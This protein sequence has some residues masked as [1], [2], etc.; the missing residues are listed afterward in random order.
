MIVLFFTYLTYLIIGKLIHWYYGEGY[1]SIFDLPLIE[2]WF[3]RDRIEIKEGLDT[4]I[5]SLKLRDIEYTILENNYY[6]RVYGLKYLNTLN[7][8]RLIQAAHRP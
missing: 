4:Y 5:D 2:K 8:L 6:Y 7:Q 3:G 1:E